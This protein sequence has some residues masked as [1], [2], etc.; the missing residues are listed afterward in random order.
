MR[1]R[2]I[3]KQ[4]KRFYQG[5]VCWDKENDVP[6][7]TYKIGCHDDKVHHIMRM[8]RKH[9]FGLAKKYSPNSWMGKLCIHKACSPYLY[10]EILEFWCIDAD[11]C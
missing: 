7:Y 3:A 10:D 8:T 4:L 2:K 6:I 5:Y 9:Y 11:R 1:V